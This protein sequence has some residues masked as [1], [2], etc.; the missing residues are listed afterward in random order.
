MKKAFIYIVGLMFVA[1][2]ALPFTAIASDPAAPVET[3]DDAGK[4][5]A[6]ADG[7]EADKAPSEDKAH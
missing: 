6:S 5:D 4:K 1:S 7:S 3:S 2:L